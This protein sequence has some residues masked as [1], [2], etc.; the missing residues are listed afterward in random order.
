[1]RGK[2]RDVELLLRDLVTYASELRGLSDV[3]IL[4]KGD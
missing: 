3:R 1:M 4:S 2:S